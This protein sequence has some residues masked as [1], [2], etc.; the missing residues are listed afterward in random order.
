MKRIEKEDL[1]KFADLAEE[2]GVKLSELAS[3]EHDRLNEELEKEYPEFCG[4]LADMITLNAVT[5]ALANLTAIAIAS[6]NGSEVI[7]H[8]DRV[9]GAIHE[10]VSG[11]IGS[12]GGKS[13]F[14]KMPGGVDETGKK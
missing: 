5:N 6:Q 12:D 4:Y 14:I 8:I 3:K 1:A 9:K 7:D 10:K 2:L 11:L 13:I